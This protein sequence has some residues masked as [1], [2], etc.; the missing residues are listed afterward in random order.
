M[1]GYGFPDLTAD[2]GVDA[3]KNAAAIADVTGTACMG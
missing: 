3:A 1:P 2:R